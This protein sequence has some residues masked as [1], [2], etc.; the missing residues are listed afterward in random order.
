LSGVITINRNTVVTDTCGARL[1][2]ASVKSIF[3]HPEA[4]ERIN[5]YVD[6]VASML[7][8]FALHWR[9][10]RQVPNPSSKDG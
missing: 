1:L 8:I 7:T 5:I 10:G 6:Q 9:I 2:I 3:N 4:G